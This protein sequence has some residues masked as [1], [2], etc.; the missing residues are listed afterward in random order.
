MAEA[1]FE[2]N[3]DDKVDDGRRDHEHGISDQVI[4]PWCEP[5]LEETKVKAD[6]IGYCPE[7]NIHLCLSCHES[8][9]K[10]PMLQKHRL[11]RGS[12]MPKSHADK[13]IRYP[14]CASHAG[15]YTDHYCSN[16][17]QMV[18]ND[19]LKNDHLG[20]EAL[21][22]SDVCKSVN[23]EDVKQFKIVVNGIQNNVKT[24]QAALQKNISDTESQKKV[25]VKTAES[26]RDKL[27]FKVNDMFKKTV[28]NINSTCHKTT[29]E[30]SE[31][32]EILSD[33]NRQLDEIIDNFDKKTITDIDAN[34]FV[35]IQNIVA[36]THECK[37]EIEDMVLRLHITELSLDLNEEVGRFHERIQ[38]GT[39]KEILKP[40]DTMK[41]VPNIAFPQ[42]KKKK[43]NSAV[44]ISKICATKTS[45]FNVKS[46]AKKSTDTYYINGMAIT[47]NG[48]LLIADGTDMMVKIFSDDNTLLTTFKM[49]ETIY[50]IAVMNDSEAVVSTADRKL[51]FLDISKLHTVSIRKSVS[52][53]YDVIC[54]TPYG[55]NIVVASW[56][57]TP[58]SLKMLYRNGKEIWSKSRGTK[59]ASLKMI[60]RNGHNIVVASRAIKPA[61]LKMI[62]RNGKEIWSI[63]T[64][65]DN[66]HLFQSPYAVQNTTF[67]GANAVVVTDW[68]KKTLTVIDVDNV[69]V[70]K[71]KYFKDKDLR[72]VAV[73]DN[74][75]FFVSSRATREILVVNDL[76]KSRVS[77]EGQSICSDPSVLLYRRSTDELYMAYSN[78][79]I[80][81]FKLSVTN[82]VFQYNIITRKEIT[83]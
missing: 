32:I 69:A 77:V 72:G 35:Q 11:L 64:G 75:N 81:R 80:D 42:P 65:P 26:E 13:P 41:D 36:S 83:Y 37:Q 63:S 31:H 55:D 20:C 79:E 10:W 51:H 28:S 21:P 27:I 66:Q 12:R 56:E 33:E 70:L 22:I 15:N 43:H 68:Q 58:A 47:S 19:C 16:H 24:T 2:K 45:S 48:T 60:N 62:D 18:C 40:L 30:I 46:T 9:K 71:I 29:S 6:A 44:D 49:P 5:C 14:G 38:L 7:C 1:A 39:P 3:V 73:D 52:L 76:A 67:N 57:T 25:M 8:H 4:D 59:P 23:T 61:S 50:D 78:G 53:G 74:G 17:E 82:Y 54:L 34:G